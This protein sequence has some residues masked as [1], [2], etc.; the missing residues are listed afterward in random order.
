MTGK[1]EDERQT[2]QAAHALEQQAVKPA[3]ERQRHAEAGHLHREAADE[4]AH[5]R[6]GGAGQT[7]AVC[8]GAL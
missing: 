2:E 6:P 8:V 3:A 5:L 4:L 1:P 7:A